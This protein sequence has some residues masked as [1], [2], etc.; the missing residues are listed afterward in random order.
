MNVNGLYVFIIS[1]IVC[2][3]FVIRGVIRNK[4]RMKSMQDIAL[5]LGFTYFP[6]LKEDLRDKL[7][8]MNMFHYE[9]WEEGLYNIWVF[10]VCCT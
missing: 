3:I 1:F 7:K 9:H 10:W 4:K 8:G 2:L 6:D 5:L